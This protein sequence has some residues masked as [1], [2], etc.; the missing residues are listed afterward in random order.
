MGSAHQSYIEAVAE[1][2]IRAGHDVG[3]TNFARGA[4]QSRSGVIVMA[5][6]GRRL[7]TFDER[8]PRVHLGWN[9]DHGWWIGTRAASATEVDGDTVEYFTGGVLPAPAWV[10]SWVDRRNAALTST[11][12]GPGDVHDEH[13]LVE[14]LSR[15][16]RSALTRA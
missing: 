6:G 13:E 11:T 1:A 14:A 12:P 2:L 16:D 7:D 5:T 4:S 10:V 9:E 15:Y 3:E 8:Q